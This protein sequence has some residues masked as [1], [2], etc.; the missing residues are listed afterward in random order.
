MEG[1]CDNVR[2][3][4]DAGTI[5]AVQYH[6]V[7][8]EWAYATVGLDRKTSSFLNFRSAVVDNDPSEPA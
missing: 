2:I 6:R 3:T 1:G 8:E 5:F 7:S 4:I